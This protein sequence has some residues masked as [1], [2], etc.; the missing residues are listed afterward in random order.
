MLRPY[1]ALNDRM[2]GLP[3][4]RLKA[5]SAADGRRYI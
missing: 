1:E 3:A 5:S 4:G 2:P